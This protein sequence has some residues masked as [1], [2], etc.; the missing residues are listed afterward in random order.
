MNR[1]VLILT[2]IALLAACGQSRQ[3]NMAE[4]S[5]KTQIIINMN[6]LSDKWEDG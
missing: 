2:L 3:N 6:Q 1:K 4:N 5:H